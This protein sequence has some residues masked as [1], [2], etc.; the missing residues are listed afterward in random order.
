LALAETKLFYYRDTSWK[1][2]MRPWPW[3]LSIALVLSPYGWAQGTV[4]DPYKAASQAYRNGEYQQ[5]VTLLNPF[6]ASDAGNKN[7]NGFI[8]RATARFKLKDFDGAI[9]DFTAVTQL[10]ATPDQKVRALGG[11]G[12]VFSEKGD[13]VHAEEDYTKVL[14]ID[15]QRLSAYFQRAATRER[16]G[17]VDDAINDLKI[18]L[19]LDP[20]LTAAYLERGLL[21]FLKG[22]YPLALADYQKASEQDPKSA[23]ALA[24]QAISN[25]RLGQNED[26]E[27]TIK[28]AIFMEPRFGSD[29]A[30]VRNTRDKGPGWYPRAAA[31]LDEL[32]GTLK[33]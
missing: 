31:A 17:K 26:A 19:I 32:L 6:L 7:V 15:N 9:A 10:D 30:W 4:P 28:A 21:L 1:I 16:L 25:F 14:E 3:L 12:V 27:A 13:L 11:R 5:A 22:K 33:K 8:M 24:G 2:L 18:V 20:S 23:E 29:M